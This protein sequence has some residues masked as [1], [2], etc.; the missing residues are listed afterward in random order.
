MAAWSW[1][2]EQVTPDDVLDAAGT[3]PVT[4]N[5]ITL[6]LTATW[7]PARRYLDWATAALGRGGD[8]GWDAAAFW[9]KRAVCRQM[10]GILA[11]NHLG[12]FLGKNNEKKSEYLTGLKV[13]ALALVRDLVIDPRNAIEHAYELATEGQARRACEVAQLFLGATDQEASTPAIV[14]LGWS[15]NFREAMCATPGKEFQGIEVELTRE[16]GPMLL[17]LGYPGAPEVLILLP[18]GA[19][20]RVCPLKEFMSEQVMAL[21]GRLRECLKSESYSSRPLGPA[22]L[23]ALNEQLGL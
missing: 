12:C 1:T 19:L 5:R 4:T 23:A 2:R 10:D 6:D 15:V 17:I 7:T 13:P 11:H 9:A 18:Q 16:H 14:A 8:D 22:F 3:I 20:L 21:N